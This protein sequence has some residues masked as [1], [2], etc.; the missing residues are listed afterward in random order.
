MTPQGN[1]RALYEAR[2]RRAEK[3][4][5]SL[6]FAAEILKFYRQV[7]SCQGDAYAELAGGAEQ[8]GALTDLVARKEPDLTQILPRY[9]V[10]LAVVEKNGPGNLVAA[11]RV[12][13]GLPPESWRAALGAYWKTA[14]VSDQA[15]G[16]FAQF[17]TRA[18]MQP[19]AELAGESVVAPPQVISRNTCPRCEGR[20]LLGVLRVEG[21]GGKRFLLCSFCLQEWEFRR[22]LCPTCGETA[23]QKLPVY[24]AEQMPHVRVEACDTC[25]LYLRTIDLTKDGHAVPIV[26][27]LAAL[28]LTLWAE[29]HGY[30]RLQ[31]NLLG[32]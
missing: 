17:F 27:D 22:I 13:G 5:T 14:G 23:E 4:A 7:A 32:T 6:P 30:A 29:E 28:P 9:R 19:A 10:F 18:L 20:P 1:T 3:L 24:V 15:I 2:L 21:D 26:D 16:A 8:V 25:K 12:I 31:P 11:A